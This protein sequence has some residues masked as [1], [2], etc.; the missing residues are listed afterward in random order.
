MERALF[1]RHVF[2]IRLDAVTAEV[3]GIIARAGAIVLTHT[4]AAEGSVA[5]DGQYVSAANAVDLLRT[6]EECGVL[7]GDLNR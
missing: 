1:L 2:T 7:K 5:I 3:A 6:L 4:E